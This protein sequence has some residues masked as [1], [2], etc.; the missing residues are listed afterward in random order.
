MHAPSFI[1][2]LQ[3]F[4][5]NRVHNK[6]SAD[7]YAIIPKGIKTVLWLPIVN[8]FVLKLQNVHPPQISMT[9]FL[10]KKDTSSQFHFQTKTYTTI[11]ELCFMAQLFLKKTQPYSNDSV[12]RTFII[13]VE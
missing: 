10:M 9:W 5:E 6:F 4:Y 12:L 3:I 13:F 8:A 1:T 11:M 7:L 2:N